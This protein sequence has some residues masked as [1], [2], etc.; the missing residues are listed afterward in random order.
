[1]FCDVPVAYQGLDRFVARKKI[2]EEMSALNK[3][4]KIEDHRLMVPRG[5]RSGAIIESFSH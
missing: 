2:I 4:V 3:L 1:M 5:D